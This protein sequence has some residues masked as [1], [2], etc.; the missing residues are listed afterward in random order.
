[1]LSQTHGISRKVYVEETK[2]LKEKKGEKK[3]RNKEK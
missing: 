2:K 1:V 3:R